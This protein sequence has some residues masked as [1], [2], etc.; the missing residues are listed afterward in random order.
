[1]HMDAPALG[2]EFLPEDSMHAWHDRPHGA[3]R[4]APQAYPAA[5]RMH[6]EEGHHM[7]GAGAVG[8]ARSG[9]HVSELAYPGEPHLSASEYHAFRDVL[10]ADLGAVP[11]QFRLRA[12]AHVSDVHGAQSRVAP[13][14]AHSQ[15]AQ[16]MRPSV[17][18]R[19]SSTALQMPLPPEFE[20]SDGHLYAGRPRGSRTQPSALLGRM[21]GHAAVSSGGGRGVPLTS[22]AD[23]RVQ[24][25]SADDTAL[26]ASLQAI[27]A[28][29]QAHGSGISMLPG[30]AGSLA[31]GGA[32][33]SLARAGSSRS[34]LA[35]SGTEGDVSARFR[36]QQSLP[37]IDP[38]TNRMHAPDSGQWSGQGGVDRGASFIGDD[39]RWRTAA[40]MQVDPSQPTR[41]PQQDTRQAADLVGL[42][43]E[44]ARVEYPAANLYNIAPPV[45][46]PTGSADVEYQDTL[47]VD[48]LGRSMHSKHFVAGPPSPPQAPVRT[49]QVD[50]L[51]RFDALC[52]ARRRGTSTRACGPASSPA[53]HCAAC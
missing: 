51:H 19:V 7:P 33:A 30:G 40:V 43:R 22:E 3:G 2:A 36:S 24:H 15:R 44:G 35:A 5:Y 16:H 23:M 31:I 46:T 27:A 25:V 1:M 20:A 47:S 39:L 52:C 37:H 13:G 10:G 42:V 21:H 50:H 34:S 45:D 41:P 26:M 14:E 11:P 49:L 53:L 29:P 17:P 9:M 48:S 6:A 4:G 8:D 28:M 32:V 12:A 18:L 38:S